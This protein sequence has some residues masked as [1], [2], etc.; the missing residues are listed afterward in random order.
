MVLLNVFFFFKDESSPALTSAESL[1]ILQE[2]CLTGLEVNFQDNKCLPLC[3]VV[4]NV[5]DVAELSS[6][7][8]LKP[9]NSS[10]SDTSQADVTPV[11]A[12]VK[13]ES[14]VKVQK[15]NLFHQAFFLTV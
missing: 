5:L 11:F 6:E 10:H 12:T 3:E 13:T 8:E 14:C 2:L 7:K 1:F 4:K 15:S 9:E